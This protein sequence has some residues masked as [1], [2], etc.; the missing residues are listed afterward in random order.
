MSTN[1]LPTLSTK[2]RGI[3]QPS[4]KLQCRL[5]R[6]GKE[7]MWH[8]VGKCVALKRNRMSHNKICDL[9][10][11]RQRLECLAWEKAALEQWQSESPRCD[12]GEKQQSCG[13]GCSHQ[14]WGNLSQLWWSQRERKDGETLRLCEYN[15]H[16]HRGVTDVTIGGFPIGARGK[17]HRGDN[18]ILELMEDSKSRMKSF[19]MLLNRRTLLY[20]ADLC[21][22]FC[23]LARLL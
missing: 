13:A 5:C 12:Y 16:M 6:K 14:I 2:W 7:T 8:V 22:I 21:N 4:K 23:N 19:S 10:G 9:R 20:T 11:R 15:K 17:W 1:T 18:K 3:V